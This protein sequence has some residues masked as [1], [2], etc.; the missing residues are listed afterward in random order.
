MLTKRTNIKPSLIAGLGCFLAEPATKGETLW[1]FSPRFDLLFTEEEYAQLDRVT[2]D[3]V[4]TYGYLDKI[5]FVGYWVVHT[6]N[7]RFCNHSIMPTM[8]SVHLGGSKY[9]M[10]ASRDLLIG[11]ELTCNYSEYSDEDSNKLVK[12]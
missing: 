8:E 10:V 12:G 9:I 7:D 5:Q 2:K 3:F 1:V 6:G 11:E 4:S